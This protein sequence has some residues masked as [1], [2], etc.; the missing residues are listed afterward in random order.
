MIIIRLIVMRVIRLKKV[1][2]KLIL[3]LLTL[4]PLLGGELFYLFLRESIDL[5]ITILLSLRFF[6]SR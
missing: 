1:I 3:K 2:E 4:N 5:L 6:I